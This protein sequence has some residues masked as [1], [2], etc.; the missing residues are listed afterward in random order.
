[1]DVVRDV[2]DKQLRDGHG[3]PIGRVDGIVIEVAAEG[4]PRLVALEVGT[5]TLA[6]RLPG[7]LA[8]RIERWV[9]RTG[10][11][12]EPFRIAWTAVRNVGI[13][14]EVAV[15]AESTPAGRRERWI[16]DRVLRWIP[17]SR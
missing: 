14:V 2:L 10:A 12:A 5:L 3:T 9:R 6:R 7:G 13:D 11:S 8:R 15:D 4:P 16:A 17:G 1:M